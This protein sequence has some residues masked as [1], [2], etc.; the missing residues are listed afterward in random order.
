MDGAGGFAC[1]E[2]GQNV[3]LSVAYV[4]LVGTRSHGELLGWQPLAGEVGAEGERSDLVVAAVPFGGEPGDEG[5]GFGAVGAGG[6]PPS[7][8]LA[9]DRSSRS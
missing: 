4:A 5:F 7:A 3:S 1:A 6:V 8:F 9:G 2:G